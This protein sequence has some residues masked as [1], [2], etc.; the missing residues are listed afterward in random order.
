MLSFAAGCAQEGA[1]DPAPQGLAAAAESSASA[2]RPSLEA[3]ATPASVPLPSDA[4]RVEPGP[5]EPLEVVTARGPVRFQVEIADEPSEREQGLMWR[6]A[7]AADRGMLFDFK[8]ESPQAF[9]MR[10]TYVPLDLIFIRDDGRIHSIAR[11][12]TPLSD[13]P[14]PS[15]GAVRGVLEINAGLAERLGINPGDQVRHPL[16]R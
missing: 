12:A 11:N 9:W 5:T 13:A 6:G 14:I 8:T 15:G 16:F 3:A 10:N 4:P 2:A 7:L 1:T